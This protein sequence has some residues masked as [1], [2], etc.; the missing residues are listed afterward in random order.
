MSFENDKEAHADEIVYDEDVFDTNETLPRRN[1]M[2]PTGNRPQSPGGSSIPRTISRRASLVNI[3][4]Y[5]PANFV[6]NVPFLPQSSQQHSIGKHLQETYFCNICFMNNPINEGFILTNCKHEFCRDCIKGYWHSRINDG[7]VFLKCFHPIEK[8][9][10]LSNNSVLNEISNDNNNNSNDNNSNNNS[11]ESETE[12]K[13]ETNENGNDNHATCGAAIS[14]MDIKAVIDNSVWD[15]FERFKT[16]I[17]NPNARQCPF[18]NATSFG[19]ESHPIIICKSCNKKYCFYHSNA[20]EMSEACE[21]YEARVIKEN[22][23]NETRINEQAKRCPGCNFPIEKVSGWFVVCFC[24]LFTL[25]LLHAISL[26]TTFVFVFVFFVF[27]FVFCC[28]FSNHMKCIKCQTSFCWLCGEVI[29]DAPVPK[30]YKDPKSACF[31]KQ[32]EGMD[33]EMPAMWI[34]ISLGCFVLLF[35]LPTFLVSVVLGVLFYPIAWNYSWCLSE[36][37][38]LY[39][40]SDPTAKVKPRLQD[41]IGMCVFYCLYILFILFS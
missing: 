34:L 7:Q 4:Q 9:Q 36:E 15:K 5:L 26:K 37:M 32:F 38:R 23:L 30:H 39:H 14:E 28:I 2:S 19:N 16:N 40:L 35:G 33:A 3:T 8:V 17:E 22:K 24:L 31:E 13:R 1:P 27:V 18:C 12:T 29:E 21:S 6:S 10:T 41:V 11:N 25:Y 20:H